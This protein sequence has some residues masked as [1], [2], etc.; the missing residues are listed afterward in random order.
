MQFQSANTFLQYHHHISSRGLNFSFLLGCK[1]CSLRQFGTFVWEHAVFLSVD[2][3]L[4]HLCSFPSKDSTVSYSK[5]YFRLCCRKSTVPFVLNSF[6]S[7]AHSLFC[8]RC[9][10]YQILPSRS[11]N[12]MPSCFFTILFFIFLEPISVSK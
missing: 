4:L 6:I 1:L 2:V 7:A 12:E 10:R 3:F 9:I 11:F 8:S 5:T